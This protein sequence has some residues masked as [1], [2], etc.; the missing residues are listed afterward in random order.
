MDETRK[1]GVSSK[2]TQK[3]WQFIDYK[4]YTQQTTVEISF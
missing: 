1:S 2:S 3:K 4:K